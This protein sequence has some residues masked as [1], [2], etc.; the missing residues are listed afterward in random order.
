MSSPFAT[1][2]FLIV[3]QLVDST[4]LVTFYRFTDAVNKPC[5]CGVFKIISASLS[6]V[7]FSL[8]YSCQSLP[9]VYL[10]LLLWLPLGSN[11][12]SWAP[13]SAVT[14]Y[15]P[16]GPIRQWELI[17]KSEFSQTQTKR[18]TSTSGLIRSCSRRSA[19]YIQQLSAFCDQNFKFHDNGSHPESKVGF[20]KVCEWRVNDTTVQSRS[21]VWPDPPVCGSSKSRI[22][23]DSTGF[24]RTESYQA[25]KVSWAKLST[26]SPTLHQLVSRMYL[27]NDEYSELLEDVRQSIETLRQTNS[28]QVDVRSVYRT[29]AFS[30]LRRNPTKWKWWTANW[31]QKLTLTIAGLFSTH[32]KSVMPELQKFCF[33]VAFV[34]VRQSIETL[35]Q[36]NSSQVDVRSVYRTHA[37][38]WLRRNPTKW[39]R[40]T[41]NWNQKLTLTIAGLFST[42]GKSVMPELQKYAQTSIEI[43]N[44]DADHFGL[45]EYELQLDVRNLSCNSGAVLSE[46]FNILAHSTENRL[47]GSIDADHFGLTEYELQL[48]VRNLSCN[49]GAVLSEYFNILA[50]STE[51]RLVGSIAALCAD[52][53]E[54]MVELSNMRKKVIISPTVANARFLEQQHYPFF[55]RTSPAMTPAK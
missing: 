46:Y 9:Q 17:L 24:C 13:P 25:I 34:M 55:F 2:C 52:S 22:V 32:G 39:K 47:V 19:E 54:A 50:H 10:D 48:D 53:I 49:S 5:D 16:L 41:A 29:H 37:F 14:D 28:S 44:R 18:H 6:E 3:T 45:T 30:W 21:F 43:A 27:S 31:D 4:G 1:V 26:I 15:G 35:R 11:V 40:W 33:S 38:S 8:H 23:S 51:N 20:V 42:H 12:G 36:I 7:N